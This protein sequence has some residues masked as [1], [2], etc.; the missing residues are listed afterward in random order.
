MRMHVLV[1]A[2]ALCVGLIPP[3]HAA[4]PEGVPT[5]SERCQALRDLATPQ[6][7]VD[8]ARFEVAGLPAADSAGPALAGTTLPEHCLFRAILAPRLGGGSHFGIG[9]EVR[10]P[11]SWNGRFVFQGG[12][13]L[14]GVLAPSYGA[15]GGAR[16]AALA[17]GFAVASTDGGHRRRS[18]VTWAVTPRAPR[19]SYA[20]R[21]RHRSE[22]FMEIRLRTEG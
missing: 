1:V 15:A 14:D 4:A 9:V 18:S 13:G 11:S 6:L 7:V 10:L 8:D 17:R 12:A 2:L 22:G 5:A 20:A 19:A 3:V 21:E 16:P